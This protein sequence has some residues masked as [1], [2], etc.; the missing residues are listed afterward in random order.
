[1]DWWRMELPFSR[2]RKIFFRGRSLEENAKLHRR[3]FLTKFQAPAVEISEPE[4]CNSTPPAIPS[5]LDSLSY[6]KASESGVPR[7]PLEC[8]KDVRDTL[9]TLSGNFPEPGI[10]RVFETTR[11]TPPLDTPILG[12]TRV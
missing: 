3:A 7:V 2:V 6:Q 12:D 4:K 8:Q 11:G 10:R 5:P 9:A 1:M